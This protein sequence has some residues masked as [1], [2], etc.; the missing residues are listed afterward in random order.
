MTVDDIVWALLIV[1]IKE[2]KKLLPA[3]HGTTPFS[4]CSRSK[5]TKPDSMFDAGEMHKTE[6]LND[7]LD[8]NIK[9]GTELTMK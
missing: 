9:M 7:L 2:C 4:I 6:D 1:S 8:M 5:K 3:K